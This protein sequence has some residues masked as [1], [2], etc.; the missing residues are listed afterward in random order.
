MPNWFVNFCPHTVL[1]RASIVT[2]AEE[3]GL[4]E[5]VGRICAESASRQTIAYKDSATYFGIQLGKMSQ[6]C[7]GT[8]KALVT[9]VPVE[10]MRLHIC[11]RTGLKSRP[12]PRRSGPVASTSARRGTSRNSGR[13]C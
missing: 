3:P 7:N 8:R 11:S 4:F 1:S 12:R 2:T 9:R 6:R 10:Q 13:S 5:V